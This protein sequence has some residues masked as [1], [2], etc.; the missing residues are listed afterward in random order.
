MA[1]FASASV[2]GAAFA[3][4]V[5]FVASAGVDAVA[6]SSDYVHHVPFLR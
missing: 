3:V 6:A 5:A 4:V 1:T 2:A